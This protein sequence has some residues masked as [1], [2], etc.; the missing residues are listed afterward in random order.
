M[1]GKKKLAYLP[2]A[3][4][5][6]H[7][8]HL[9]IIN[10]AAALD[11]TVMVGCY[12]DEAIASYKRLPF[13]N[14]EQRKEVIESI[15]GVD[16]VVQQRTR[17]LEENIRKYK[18]DYV[19]H[20]TDWCDGSLSGVRERTIKILQEWNGTLI[21]PEYTKNISSTVAH[22]HLKQ[23]GTSPIER[24]SRLRKLLKVKG[25]LKAMQVHDALSALTVENARVDTPGQPT[26]EFDAFWFNT[27]TLALSKG[28]YDNAL[29]DLSLQR[30]VLND[31]FDITTKPLIF[32]GRNIIGVKQFSFTV[33]M[34][35]QLG[36]SAI[37]I[38]D[39][40]I[41]D[42]NKILHAGKK[43]QSLRDFMII[44]KVNDVLLERNSNDLMRTIYGYIDA[45]V[46]AIMLR[47][48]D[49]NIN[50]IKHILSEI[51][52][53]QIDIPIFILADTYNITY[54][55]GQLDSIRH[56]IIYNN[57][58]LTSAYTAMKNEVEQVLNVKNECFKDP[59]NIS[60]NSIESILPQIYIEK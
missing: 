48:N 59:E 27:H 19:V 56:C 8:G 37:I 28:K 13:M 16:I 9:N 41:D 25:F 10:I 21:E 2:M 45:F 22:I 29:I 26:L 34:L 15:K 12:S 18:P 44:I 17:D 38:E 46:D 5:M 31:I 23:V 3:V 20:G 4:D 24:S 39:N 11:A 57:H 42:I 53:N 52:K 32:D 49:N 33:R 43:N 1:L 60:I 58:M 7:P 6:I 47:Y 36:V 14:Y 54:I 55:Q 30:S 51:E 50:G 35:N 40:G